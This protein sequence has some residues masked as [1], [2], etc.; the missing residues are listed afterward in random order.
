M[1]EQI[2]FGDRLFLRGE[3]VFFDNGGNDAVIESRNGTLIIRGNLVVEGDTT[4]VNSIETVFADPFITLNADFEGSPTENVGIEVNRGDLDWAR[5]FWNET[6]DYWSLDD[7]DFH[8][9]GNIVAYN[10]TTTGGVSANILSDN[11]VVIVDITG[12]GSVDIRAGNIDNTVI[13]ATTPVA[14]YFTTITGDGTDIVNV[15]TNY[16]TDD[17]SEGT[18]NLYYTEERVDD[19]FDQLFNAGYSLQSSYDDGLNAY[20]L[21]YIAQNVGSGSQIYDTSNTSLSSF[22]TIV[23]GNG[24]NGGN[25]DLTVSVVGDEI[26]IDT[27]IKIN[28]LAFNSFTGIGSLSIYTLPYSVSAE[29]QILLYIDGVVQEPINSYTVS[30]NTITL[31]SPLANGSVMNVIR[32]ATNVS[33]ASVVNADT[34]DGQL[35]SYYL[36]YNNFSNTPTNHMVTDSNNIVSGNIEPSTDNVYNLGSPSNQWASVYGHSIEATYADLAERYEADAQYDAGTVVILG[37]DKEITTTTV[38]GDHRVVGVVSTDPAYLMNSTAG[39]STTH[40]AIAL[41]GRVPCKVVGPVK[42]GD[43]LV[44]SIHAGYAVV[45]SNPRIGTVIGKAISNYD[46]ND[47]GMVEI[48]VSMM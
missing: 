32:L 2:K 26:I 40:P 20:T 1:S 6:E 16:T 33:S 39:D 42:K 25:N 12:D 38:E 31:S 7:K 48:L 15:L 29:W 44:S 13:G 43:M 9:T 17:M 30:T 36:D 35:P 3:S 8:T 34:L 11:G 21:N 10:I 24:L 19:R 5:I 47:F 23:S 27:A 28:Q 18:T 4:T 37:G 45:S 46:K 14:G 41:K 22:R